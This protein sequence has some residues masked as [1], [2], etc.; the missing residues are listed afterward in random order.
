[1]R[2]KPGDLRSRGSDPFRRG[3]IAGA[4]GVV[5]VA[6]GV[7]EAAEP[8]DGAGA[9]IGGEDGWRWRRRHVDRRGAGDPR[10]PDDRA[11]QPFKPSA[12]ASLPT[13]PPQRR[14][15][16]G[17]C[18]RSP[19]GTLRRPRSPR[20]PRRGCAV[21][22]AGEAQRPRRGEP[23][24]AAVL[25]E[26]ADLQRVFRVEAEL[27]RQLSHDPPPRRA[28]SSSSLVGGSGLSRASTSLRRWRAAQIRTREPI[29]P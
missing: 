6:A 21:R 28:R 14:E 4:G 7:G 3:R 29:W 22:P 5:D 12:D 8:G 26:G 17:C 16:R 9:E 19:Q 24:V 11:P 1:M 27:D 20:P 13:P 2:C 25:G 10:G 15:I 18:T 23:H